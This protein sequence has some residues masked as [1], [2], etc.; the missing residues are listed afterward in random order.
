MIQ[1]NESEVGSDKLLVSEVVFH[2]NIQYNINV[3]T[4][5][6]VKLTVQLL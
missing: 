1:Q 5:G 2:L 3:K 4:G 6:G